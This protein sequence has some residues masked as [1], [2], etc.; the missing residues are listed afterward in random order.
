MKKNPYDLL[1]KSLDQPLKPDERERL[2]ASLE[3]SAGLRDS[4]RR[5]TEMRQLFKAA[6]P[7]RFEPFFATR[8]MANLRN[9]SS[10]REVDFFELLKMDFRTLVLAALL[11]ILGLMSYNAIHEKESFLPAEVSVQQALDPAFA[12]FQE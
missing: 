10:T 3:H 5:L 6:P 1:L 11:F 12:Y 8:V 9:A 4:A 2:N 7:L